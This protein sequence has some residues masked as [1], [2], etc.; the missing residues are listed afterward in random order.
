M[1]HV[2][3]AGVVARGGFRIRKRIKSKRKIMSRMNSAEL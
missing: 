2:R 3:R 1:R